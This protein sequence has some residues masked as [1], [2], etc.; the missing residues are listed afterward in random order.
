MSVVVPLLTVAA[1]FGVVAL[2]LRETARRSGWPTSSSNP[3]DFGDL[4]WSGIVWAQL[5][6]F[7]VVRNLFTVQVRQQGV[8]LRPLFPLSAFLAPRCISWQKITFAKKVWVGATWE[9]WWMDTVLFGVPPTVGRRFR[10]AKP[11]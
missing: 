5:G 6:R 3:S 11:P 2:L 7:G 9:L 4:V 10:D 8:M 1:L